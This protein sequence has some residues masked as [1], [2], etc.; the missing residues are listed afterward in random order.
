MPSEVQR[1]LPAMSTRKTILCIHPLN[2]I[3]ERF[4]HQR[5]CTS[6]T[7]NHRWKDFTKVIDSGCCIRLNA[8]WSH[9]GIRGRFV[10]CS[11]HDD[12]QCNVDQTEP[13]LVAENAGLRNVIKCHWKG[14]A[15]QECRIYVNFGSTNVVTSQMVRPPIHTDRKVTVSYIHV[16]M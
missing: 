10:K 5:C 11:R 16:H 2:R 3:C 6:K 14:H 7:R 12:A 4:K 8:R 15:H 1:G 13:S 9:L